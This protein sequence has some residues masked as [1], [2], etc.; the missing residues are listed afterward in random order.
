MNNLEEFYINQAGSGITGFS[1]V[2]YQ[3][4][5]GFFGRLM[6]GAIMPC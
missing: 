4:G 6:K 1:G 5:S 3:R 2:R